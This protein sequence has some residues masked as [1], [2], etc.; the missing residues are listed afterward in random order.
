MTDE[1]S[2]DHINHVLR[3]LGVLDEPKQHKTKAVFIPME[4]VLVYTTNGGN[5]FAIEPVRDRTEFIGR[6]QIMQFKSFDEMSDILR[7]H[8]EKMGSNRA[9]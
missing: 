5:S 3:M 8:F 1:T 9:T 4:P 7:K 6:E 2:P